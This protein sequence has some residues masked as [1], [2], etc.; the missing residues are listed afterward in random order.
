MF[1]EKCCI[2]VECGRKRLASECLLHQGGMRKEEVS[3]EGLLHQWC[4]KLWFWGERCC[5]TAACGRKR[6]AARVCYIVDAVRDA[7]SRGRKR[8]A[9]ECL[10]H[11]WC[12]TLG[13]RG[14]MLLEGC[15]ITVA[16][17]RSRLVSVCCIRVNDATNQGSFEAGEMSL[18]RLHRCC[19]KLRAREGE[20]KGTTTQGNVARWHL[21]EL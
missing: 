11:Q 20:K 9:S 16:C 19:N 10:L 14:W 17:V 15:C 21:L 5:I 4:N 3:G 8:L 18:S 6:L 2:T 7:A 13:F 1:L 12:N